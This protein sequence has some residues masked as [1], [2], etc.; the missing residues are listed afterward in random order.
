MLSLIKRKSYST[1]GFL[2]TQ[3]GN[4]L[5]RPI[6]SLARPKILGPLGQSGRP[7]TKIGSAGPASEWPTRSAGST[8]IQNLEPIA[9]TAVAPNI[10]FP[11]PIAG[12]RGKESRRKMKSILEHSRWLY[13]SLLLINS[14]RWSFIPLP[15]LLQEI[16][17]AEHHQIDHL[18]SL[19]I[20]KSSAWFVYQFTI[21]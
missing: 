4:G 9:T 2:Y 8:H 13:F 21:S 12:I 16:T 20:Y 1:N 11:F 3:N 15:F 5:G 10:H 17:R 7:Y 6:G 19:Y 14:T 18:P